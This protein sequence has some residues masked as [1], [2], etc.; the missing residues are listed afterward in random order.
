LAN[1]FP[2]RGG[3]KRGLTWRPKRDTMAGALHVIMLRPQIRS[4]L[5]DTCVH[6]SRLCG[7]KQV[8]KSSAIVYV[9]TGDNFK[10]ETRTQSMRIPV[11]TI[12]MRFTE[13]HGHTIST[14]KYV[15]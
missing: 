5:Q 13:T 3:E 14:S 2:E 1:F 8:T 11:M 6:C 12:L 9:L 15:A 10:L 4:Q 7:F